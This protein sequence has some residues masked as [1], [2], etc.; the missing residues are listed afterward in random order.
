[1]FIDEPLPIDG[2]IELTD[3][4]GFGLTLNKERLNLKR[5][6]PER[7]KKCE[8]RAGGNDFLFPAPT[9]PWRAESHASDSRL[10]ARQVADHPSAIAA[11]RHA[12]GD[13]RRAL[14]GGNSFD[15]QSATVSP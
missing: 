15:T 4:P 6:Y 11:V 3:K 9:Q 1:M 8:F 2:Y 13:L 14:P 7:K 10:S 12:A 5:P